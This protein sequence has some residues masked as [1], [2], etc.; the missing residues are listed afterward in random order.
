M[1]KKILLVDDVKFF[2]ELE[3][4][5][6]KRTDCE[7][8][9]AYDGTEALELIRSEKPN[10]V[11]MD[12]YMPKLNGDEC[13]R[14]VKDDPETRDIPIIMVT[15]A[16]KEEERKKSELAGCDDYITKPINRMELLERVKHHLDIPIR[17][18][19]R[20]PIDIEASYNINNK[21]YSGRIIEISEGGLFFES[22]SLHSKGTSIELSFKIPESSDIL[23]KAEGKVARAM[24]A[25]EAGTKKVRQGMGIKFSYMTAEA[26]KVIANYIKMGNYMV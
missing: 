24:D 15:M 13:C 11:L 2:V 5:F 16:G 22:E 12:L 23:I 9:T 18:Y 10:L 20:A 6:L 19:P 25:S 8:L 7:I 3:K 14:K 26:K 4:T 21:Q 17:K 1:A